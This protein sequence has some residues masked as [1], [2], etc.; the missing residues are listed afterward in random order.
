MIE[1]H[2]ER[3]LPDWD[4][5]EEWGDEIMPARRTRRTH[6]AEWTVLSW[7]D[8][9]AVGDFRKDPPAHYE[10]SCRCSVKY[11]GADGCKTCPCVTVYRKP[12]P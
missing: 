7:A 3:D 4:E 6:S 11:H 8:T 5:V 9:V 12:K 2:A 10:C 1:I